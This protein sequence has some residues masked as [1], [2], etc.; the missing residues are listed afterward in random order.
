M[1]IHIFEKGLETWIIVLLSLIFIM[2]LIKLVT[3]KNQVK[4]A[5]IN[6][7]ISCSEKNIKKNIFIILIIVFVI[8]LL[9]FVIVSLIFKYWF[10]MVLSFIIILNTITF[11]AIEIKYKNINGIYENGIIAYFKELFEWKKIHSYSITDNKLTGYLR[12]GNIFEFKNIENI[13]KIEYLF[14]KNNIKHE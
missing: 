10:F 9:Y 1:G 7:Y 6:Y 3:L 8:I 11:C 2:F 4:K 12:N 13:Y 14:A 5:G